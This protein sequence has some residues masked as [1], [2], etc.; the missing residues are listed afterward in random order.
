MYLQVNYYTAHRQH[1]SSHIN[2]YLFFELDNHS[3]IHL[4]LLE[5]HSIEYINK[6]GFLNMYIA[7]AFHVPFPDHSSQTTLSQCSSSL[8]GPLLVTHTYFTFGHTMYLN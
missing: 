1:Y 3:S 7:V 6:L 2:V 4:L 8:L 5:F